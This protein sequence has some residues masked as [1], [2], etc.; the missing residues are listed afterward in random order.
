MVFSVF[1]NR[2]DTEA[3]PVSMTWEKWSEELTKLLITE[4]KDTLCFVL[5]SISEGETHSK[6]TVK[7]IEALGLDLDDISEEDLGKALEALDPYEFVFYTS[8]SHR[9]DL[10]KARIILPLKE[11][12]R[13]TE[14]PRHWEALNRL[15][16][17]LNDPQTKDVSRLFYVHSTNEERKE[18]EIAFRHEGEFYSLKK[19]PVVRE[20]IPAQPSQPSPEATPPTPTPQGIQ[21]RLTEAD[22]YREAQRRIRRV[23]VR[24][25][26][27]G[28]ML[29]SLSKGESLADKGERESVRFLL[30]GILV[31]QWPNLD[32]SRT[33]E[34]FRKSFEVMHDESPLK[35]GVDGTIKEVRYKLD[36]AKKRSEEKRAEREQRRRTASSQLNLEARGDGLDSA[37]S[38]DDLRQIASLQRCSLEELQGRWITYRDGTA[39]FLNMQGYQGPFGKNDVRSLAHLYLNP[40]PDVSAYHPPT[41][42]GGSRVLK[43]Y[44][45]LC[46]QYGSV[47]REVEISLIQDVTTFDKE[48]GKIVEAS[49][50]RDPNLRPTRSDKVHRWLHILGGD[51]RAKLF[52]WISAVPHLDRPCCALYL[53]GAKGTGKTFLSTGLAR[54][55]GVSDVTPLDVVIDGFNER[56]ARMPLVVADEFLPDVKNLSGKLRALIGSASHTIQRKYRSEATLRGSARVVVLA[57]TPH[58]LDLKGDHTKEDLDAISERFL[59]IQTPKEASTYLESLSREEKENFLH[60]EIAEHCLWLAENWEREEGRRFVVEGHLGDASLNIAINNERSA[61]LC[62]FLVE[63]LT[64]PNALDANPKTKG[65]IQVLD[66]SLWVNSYAVQKAWGVFMDGHPMSARAIGIAL[67]SLASKDEESFRRKTIDGRRRSFYQVD[68]DLLA[69]WSEAHGR[70]GREDIASIIGA[71]PF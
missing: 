61:L 33:A 60:K 16:G 56:L 30:C 65:L 22:L 52:D 38:E 71:T 12:I 27:S 55:W 18:H 64:T 2:F 19:V 62:E 4:E 39:Y 25:R 7:T 35:V 34:L 37:Y 40:V 59:F 9:P 47:I 31:D 41:R 20:E 1:Q 8:H 3:K 32:V 13:P 68:T 48:S 11:A 63:Y 14:Q 70:M 26:A 23:S 28:Q 46:A 50:F 57:N 36:R 24:D 53:W 21:T 5:G 17:G 29:K 69:A 15:I 44:N 45:E 54:I 66:G 6:D 49:A 10:I 43:G 51:D 67:K 42:Q 58:L